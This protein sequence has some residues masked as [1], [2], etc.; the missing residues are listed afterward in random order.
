VRLGFEEAVGEM[1]AALKTEDFGVLCQIDIQT[2]L[3]EKL[4]VEFPRYV[5]LAPETGRRL[6]MPG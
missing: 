4:G 1:E 2:K 5:I 6:Q 3:N